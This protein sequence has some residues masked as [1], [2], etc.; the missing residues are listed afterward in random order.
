MQRGLLDLLGHL[1]AA[2]M[3]L[4][5]PELLDVAVEVPRLEELRRGVPPRLAERSL[6]SQAVSRNLRKSMPKMTSLSSAAV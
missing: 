5:V 2:V 1:R 6:S 4:A 3:L